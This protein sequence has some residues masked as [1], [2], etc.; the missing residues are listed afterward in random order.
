M[1]INRSI[2]NDAAAG[3]SNT[4]FLAPTQQGSENTNGRAHF[5][6]DVVGRDTVYLLGSHSHGAA[7][8]FHLRTEVSENLEPVIRVAQV[9]NAVDDTR[10]PRQKWRGENRERGSV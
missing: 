4:G 6:Y 3:Q 5:P 9:R 7:R 2:P 8:A 10:G 1:Q